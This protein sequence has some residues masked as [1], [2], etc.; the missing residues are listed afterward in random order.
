VILVGPYGSGKTHIALQV[1]FLFSRNGRTVT[2]ID[3]EFGC[4]KELDSLY[5]SKKISDKDIE[6]I[7]M[8]VATTWNSFSDVIS[9]CD[10]DL[11]IV[12]CMSEVM[13]LFEDYLKEKYL[14]QGYYVVGGKEIKIKDKDVFTT[15]WELTSR[16]YDKLLE[17]MYFLVKHKKHVLTT[18]HPIGGTPARE[19]LQNSLMAKVDTVIEL[20]NEISEG[21]MNF[22]GV[23]RKN[24]GGVSGVRIKNP[25]DAVL[26]MFEKVI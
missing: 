13:R 26:K 10:S 21:K 17:I 18:I 11:T 2:Y 8:K 6:N 4:Q 3:P 22:Y 9:N 16:V 7:D 12:D 23:I 14:T 20:E 1:A 19:E 5:E 15:P 25:G 24:R